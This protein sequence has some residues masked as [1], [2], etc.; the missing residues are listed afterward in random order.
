MIDAIKN[1]LLV[2]LT[3]IAVVAV[4]LLAHEKNRTETLQ[5]KVTSL[6]KEVNTANS[7][8]ARLKD[9]YT[10][11]DKIVSDLLDSN[12]SLDEIKEKLSSDLDKN[13]G[14]KILTFKA[15]QD[16]KEKVADKVADSADA[17]LTSSM[18]D[19]YCSVQPDDTDCTSRLIANKLRSK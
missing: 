18:W 8:L 16:E 17:I 19:A 6:T 14:Q 5:D 7:E 1:A 15:K 11:S 3:V 13:L 2:I 10:I 12:Q 9:S 4:G